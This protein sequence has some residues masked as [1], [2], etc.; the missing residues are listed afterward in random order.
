VETEEESSSRSSSASSYG[1]GFDIS[2]KTALESP[3]LESIEGS[4]KERPSRVSPLSSE[5]AC[6]RT[7]PEACAVDEEDDAVFVVVTEVPVVEDDE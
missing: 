6:W 2:E 4:A 5:I 3:P 7:T 1:A